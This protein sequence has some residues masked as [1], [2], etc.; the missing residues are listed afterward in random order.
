MN[1][2]NSV[3]KERIK[4]YYDIWLATTNYIKYKDV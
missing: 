1:D 3:D 2:P 4:L